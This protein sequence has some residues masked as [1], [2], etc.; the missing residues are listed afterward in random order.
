M[1]FNLYRITNL[2]L[3]RKQNL[4]A[5]F[6][7]KETLDLENLIKMF[8]SFM[9]LL[10]ISYTPLCLIVINNVSKL[11]WQKYASGLNPAYEL[12]YSLN[13]VCIIFYHHYH[14]LRHII[15]SHGILYT[16]RTKISRICSITKRSKQSN[17]NRYSTTICRCN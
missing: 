7:V 12:I 8:N 10:S 13:N 14:N 5:K 9:N 6:R 3:V 4:N 2:L 1:H 15:S 16:S 17:I 11:R